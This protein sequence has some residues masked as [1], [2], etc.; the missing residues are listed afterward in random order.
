MGRTRAGRGDAEGHQSALLFSASKPKEF[1]LEMQAM[2]ELE[3][4]VKSPL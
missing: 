4:S 3:V 2:E 1:P